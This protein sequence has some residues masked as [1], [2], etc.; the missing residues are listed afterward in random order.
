MARIAIL[1]FVALGLGSCSSAM[2]YASSV[3][4]RGAY[5]ISGAI[6]PKAERQ[7]LIK[8]LEKMT[9]HYDKAI[10]EIEAR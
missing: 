10:R 9:H 7:R 3:S 8:S 2:D 1:I 6:T 5:R 4:D